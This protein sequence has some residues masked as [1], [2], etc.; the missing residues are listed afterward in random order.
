[1]HDVRFL[2]Y[3][4]GTFDANCFG[5]TRLY[6]TISFVFE[7]SPSSEAIRPGEENSDWTWARAL[8]REFV[9]VQR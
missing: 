4:E 8:P 2:G 3:Y 9:I 6:H 5:P 7:A 1:V